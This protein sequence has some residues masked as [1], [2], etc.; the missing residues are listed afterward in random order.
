MT[1]ESNRLKA[2]K[3]IFHNL[4]L[5]DTSKKI[6][7]K[8]NYKYVSW[9][10]AVAEVSKKY[11]DNFSYE[12]LENEEGKPFFYDDV[13]GYWVKTKVKIQDQEKKMML[14]VLDSA[15]RV[16]KKESYFYEVKNK[17]NPS[18]PFKKKA[19]AID[20]QAINKAI[21]RCLVKNLALFGFGLSLWTKDDIYS[22]EE[23]QEINIIYITSKQKEELKNLI[24]ETESD[25]EALCRIYH[26]NQIAELPIELF[27]KMKESLEAKKANSKKLNNKENENI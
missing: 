26:I 11:P 23:R 17:Q 8:S 2:K 4:S 21:M 16:L 13:A 27:K 5:I 3:S 15:N 19:E 18:Q 7:T 12:I 24:Q 22:N 9:A 14:P 20:I 1:R 25:E 10:D 6:Q